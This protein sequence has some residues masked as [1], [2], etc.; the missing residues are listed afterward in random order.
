MLDQQEQDRKNEV[1]ARE[2][3]AQDFM[4]RM[5]DG[6]LKDMDNM[7]KKE[8]EM[9]V[10]YER[11][12]EQKMRRE[13]EEKA[14][15]KQVQQTEINK[16]LSKQQTDKKSKEKE[17]KDDINQQA[18]MWQKDRDI[19]KVE[20]ERIQ[21]KIYQINK[22]TQQ[23]LKLQEDQKAQGKSKKMVQTEKQLNKGLMRE[24]KQKQKDMKL[25]QE[26]QS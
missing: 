23:F 3:R 14:K 21:K 24:I 4:N 17:H 8:D 18:Q 19:W 6:V 15:K 12:R 13:E 11:E 26:E 5:A 16:M 10:R 25:Q 7:Q 2:K 20:E 1:N 9:I 22:E